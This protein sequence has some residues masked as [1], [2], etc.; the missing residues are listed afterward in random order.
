LVLKF[1]SII[2]GADKIMGEASG[3]RLDI[4]LGY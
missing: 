1:P 4:S 3:I 2:E